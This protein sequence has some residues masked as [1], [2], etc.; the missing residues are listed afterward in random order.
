MSDVIVNDEYIENMKNFMNT[1]SQQFEDCITKYNLILTIARTNGA[2]E[3]E[4]AEALS[5]FANAASQ[6]SGDLDSIAQIGTTLL[7]EYLRQVDE[8]D[9]YLY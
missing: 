4:F 9:K 5:Q 1:Q 3:G 2:Y 7:D 6:L 8:A